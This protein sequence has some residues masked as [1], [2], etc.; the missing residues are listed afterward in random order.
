[1]T[2]PNQPLQVVTLPSRSPTEKPKTPCHTERD[3][4]DD[5]LGSNLVGVTIHILNQGD[6][7]LEQSDYS[8][9][10]DR[11]HDMGATV[12]INTATSRLSIYD[13]YRPHGVNHMD[14][15]DDNIISH[16][17]CCYLGVNDHE[18]EQVHHT[19]TFPH[20]HVE[21]DYTTN[22]ETSQ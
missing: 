21:F 12:L 6:T 2:R 11:R 5:D 22:Y 7:V 9:E 18:G 19:R 3:H 8:N 13:R 15:D 17:R 10:S 14:V 16:T 4:H 20:D 1:M